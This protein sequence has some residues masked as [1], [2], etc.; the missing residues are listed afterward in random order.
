[1]NKKYTRTV[2]LVGAFIAITAT[3][4]AVSSGQF[5]QGN[6]SARSGE[7]NERGGEN[8]ASGENQNIQSGALPAWCIANCP[9]GSYYG[10]PKYIP[11]TDGKPGYLESICT[12]PGED[13]PGDTG[14]GTSGSG[15]S[16]GNPPS[17]TG[18]Y[19][20]DP[21]NKKIIGKAPVIAKN[22]SGKKDG[23]EKGLPEFILPRIPEGDKDAKP[24][25][26]G[27]ASLPKDPGYPTVTKVPGWIPTKGDGKIPTGNVDTSKIPSGNPGEKMTYH[28]SCGCNQQQVSI[29]VDQ[30]AKK[31]STEAFSKDSKKYT[32]E[33]PGNGEVFQAQIGPKSFIEVSTSYS[34]VWCD[35]KWACPQG[36]TLDHAYFLNQCDPWR[37]GFDEIGGLPSKIL[38][39]KKRVCQGQQPL[40]LDQETINTCKAYNPNFEKEMQQAMKSLETSTCADFGF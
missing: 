22:S 25:S 10:F 12:L 8:A 24:G 11:P 4:A 38:E 2:V 18:K 26:E 31:S 30:K 35:E 7:R 33:C 16:G 20:F 14:D 13:K 15:G 3:A 1:M 36:S 29:F 5:F 39:N 32:F 28:A 19:G 27:S 40:A 6:F 23:W 34:A 9:N 37:K 17:G 21:T